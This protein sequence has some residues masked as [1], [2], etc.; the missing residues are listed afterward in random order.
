MMSVH[1]SFQISMDNEGIL[2]SGETDLHQVRFFP[3]LTDIKKH[4]NLET[5]LFIHKTAVKLV[6][7]L[8]LSIKITYFLKKYFLKSL[9]W[10]C[11][12]VEYNQNIII[13]FFS[14]NEQMW[15]GSIDSLLALSPTAIFN[16]SLSMST[17][18]LIVH[19]NWQFSVM[20]TSTAL[21]RRHQRYSR[22]CQVNK[23][24]TSTES[25]VYDASLAW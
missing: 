9:V 13:W 11:V 23:N 4:L 17:W 16:L 6:L 3:T 7:I 18:H 22:W 20:I 14:A 15:E 25:S 21:Q 1:I 24:S 8:M 10:T 12:S 19:Q 2:Y 5:K